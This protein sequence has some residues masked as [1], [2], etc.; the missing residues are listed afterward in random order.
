MR[1]LVYASLPLG[2]GIVVDPFMGA[3]STIAAAEAV[4]YQCVG[5]ERYADYYN[6]AVEAVPHFR[7][8]GANGRCGVLSHEVQQSLEF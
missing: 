2:E 6:L 8:L 5:I 4:G 7:A 3:G 1:Q